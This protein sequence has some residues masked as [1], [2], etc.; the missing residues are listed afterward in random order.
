MRLVGIVIAYDV[1]PSRF[2]FTLDDS[3]GATVDVTCERPKPTVRL[4]N[5]RSVNVTSTSLQDL[6]RKGVTSSRKDIDLTGVDVGT[7]VKIKGLIGSWRAER[8]LLLERI[9]IVQS[10]NEEA[11]AWTENQSFYADTLGRPWVLTEKELKTARQK[12]RID[13][14]RSRERSKASKTVGLHRNRRPEHEKAQTEDRSTRK[15]AKA[16]ATAQHQKQRL[17]ERREREREMN[18][19][20]HHRRRKEQSHRVE[21]VQQDVITDMHKESPSSAT[22]RSRSEAWNLV[23]DEQLIENQRVREQTRHQ[24][25][26]DRAERERVFAE[27]L[28]RS[29][30]AKG[31][32]LSRSSKQSRVCKD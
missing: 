19:R 6:T 2:I 12:A 3:S 25:E 28:Q 23:V 22:N 16:K 14:D 32:E 13:G 20:L 5:V 31:S 30:H 27:R 24:R 21:Q 4:E 29:S 15:Q 17:Q 1:L 10:T 8:Q 11:V 7:I 26:V 18:N 9:W